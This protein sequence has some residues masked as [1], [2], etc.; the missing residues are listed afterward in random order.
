VLAKRLATTENHGQRM[1]GSGFGK[2]TFG[3][4][5][6]FHMLAAPVKSI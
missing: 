6:I 3:K 1:I 5:R 2:A 4:L